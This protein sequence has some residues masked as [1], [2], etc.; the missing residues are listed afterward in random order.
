MENLQQKVG[1]S[2]SLALDKVKISN[3]SLDS[4]PQFFA[5][6]VLITH[7]NF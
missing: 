5:Y 7:L 6:F 1:Q 2:Q 3:V 4:Q